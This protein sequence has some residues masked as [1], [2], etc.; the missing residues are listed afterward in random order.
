MPTKNA[1]PSGRCTSALGTLE[2]PR[3]VRGPGGKRDK[4]AALVLRVEADD[5]ETDKGHHYFMAGWRRL[6]SW[7]GYLVAEGGS[8]GCAAPFKCQ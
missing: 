1:L 7:Y 5:V 6:W 8:N 4:P 2:S 3:R